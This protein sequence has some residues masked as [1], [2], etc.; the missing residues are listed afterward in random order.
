MTAPLVPWLGYVE[1]VVNGGGSAPAP[2]FLTADDGA[3]VLTADDGAT[4]LEAA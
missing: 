3:T 1:F 2:V 4:A